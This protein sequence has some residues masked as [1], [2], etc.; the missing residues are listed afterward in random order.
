MPKKP[1]KP[2][3]PKQVPPETPKDAKDKLFDD[4]NLIIEK[5]MPDIVDGTTNAMKENLK[6]QVAAWESAIK[7]DASSAVM[8]IQKKVTKA[9]K[10]LEKNKEDV[11]TMFIS[12]LDDWAKATG[13][14]QSIVSGLALLESEDVRNML[15]ELPKL[16]N[17]IKNRDKTIT[18]DWRKLMSGII[19][20]IVSVVCLALWILDI[21]S[22]F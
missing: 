4:I 17:K 3:P 18:V 10:D 12:K 1:I 2:V 21:I 14:G 9:I 15:L 16:W 11:A 20:L 7:A 8:E 6:R 22:R 19:G 5:I 13:A